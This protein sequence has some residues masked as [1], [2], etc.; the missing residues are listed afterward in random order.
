MQT[1]GTAIQQ[2][3]SW[4]FPSLPQLCPFSK[5]HPSILFTMNSWHSKRV[6]DLLRVLKQ[7]RPHDVE[8]A[9]PRFPY[10]LKM[11]NT[12]RKLKGLARKNYKQS[13][14]TPIPE[15][16]KNSSQSR[17]KR[18]TFASQSGVRFMVN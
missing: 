11:T 17:A 15:V 16:I 4:G 13:H 3:W 7:K 1:G 2:P 8:E 18:T 9:K 10:L 14:Y 6:A 5:P 12:N